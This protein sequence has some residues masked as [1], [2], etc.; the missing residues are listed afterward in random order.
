MSKL[1]NEWNTPTTS[2]KQEYIEDTSI[3]IYEYVDIYNFIFILT[4]QNR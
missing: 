4:P 1:L 2:I 3:E